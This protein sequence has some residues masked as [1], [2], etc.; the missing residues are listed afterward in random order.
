MSEDLTPEQQQTVLHDTAQAAVSLAIVSI[1]D[2]EAVQ[3]KKAKNLKLEIDKN[4]LNGILLTHTGTIDRATE[5]LLFAKIPPEYRLYLQ[6]SMLLLNMYYTTPDLGELLHEED[7]KLLVALFKGVSD[8][9]QL[10][11]DLYEKDVGYG[12]RSD[13]RIAA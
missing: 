5:K 7:W 6:N 9:C 8:G 3:L 1:Y 10:I 11:I 2:D 4:I 13:Y 12:I